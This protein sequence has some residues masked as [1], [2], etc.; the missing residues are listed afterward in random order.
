MKIQSFFLNVGP[1]IKVYPV[2]WMNTETWSATD[3]LVTLSV[4]EEE[5]LTY[6]WFVCSQNCTTF[7]GLELN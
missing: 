1:S 7:E 3:K 2:V 6:I 4:P 5:R